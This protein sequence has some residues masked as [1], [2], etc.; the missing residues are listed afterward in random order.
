MMQ[1]SKII[2]REQ[3]LE[4]EAKEKAKQEVIQRKAEVAK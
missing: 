4:E 3:E 1:K 2:E